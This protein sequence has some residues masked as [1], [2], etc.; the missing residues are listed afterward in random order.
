MWTLVGRRAV[1]L[2]LAEEYG[3]RRV[4][5]PRNA[6]RRRFL[7]PFQSMSEGRTVLGRVLPS[8]Q[9]PPM[10]LFP[11]R[12]IDISKLCVSG[13]KWS[14]KW[15]ALVLSL[16]SEMGAATLFE[17]MTRA[18]TQ[19]PC[20]ITIISHTHLPVGLSGSSNSQPSRRT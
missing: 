14:T 12:V 4:G 7:I 2:P 18:I 10:F 19:R 20:C 5:R 3:H 11:F 8:P 17:P 16:S 15:S 6:D 1:F 13:T 9:T